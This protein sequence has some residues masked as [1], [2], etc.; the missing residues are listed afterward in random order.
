[1]GGIL[2]MT[3]KIVKP[4]TN[5]KIMNFEKLLKN[6]FDTKNQ[7]ELNIAHILGSPI[8]CSDEF[9]VYYIE[10]IFIDDDGRLSGWCIDRDGADFERPNIFLSRDDETKIINWL[11]NHA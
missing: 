9:G 11:T 6:W 10:E 8:A 7:T 2:M 5:N 4:N 1:M 3:I